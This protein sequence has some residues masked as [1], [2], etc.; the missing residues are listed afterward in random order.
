MVCELSRAASSHSGMSCSL[1]WYEYKG[2]RIIE[3]VVFTF[4]CAFHSNW[5]LASVAKWEKYI[6]FWCNCD[7]IFYT[8]ISIK[9]FHEFP[10]RRFVRSWCYIGTLVKFG[11][12][13]KR[14][15]QFHF[16]FFF[17]SFAF[18]NFIILAITRSPR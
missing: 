13:L 9:I 2:I 17:L 1:S 10:R 14:Y 4:L 5:L 15:T 8:L 7:L 6:V 3:C 12:V 11:R 16:F 18:C